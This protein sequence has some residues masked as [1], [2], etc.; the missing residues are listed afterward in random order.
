VYGVAA[1]A[2]GSIPYLLILPSWLAVGPTLG[3]PIYSLVQ[4]SLEKY[5]LF[6]LIQHYG[7]W[8]GLDNYSSVLHDHVFWDT[9]KRT[10]VFTIANVGLTMVSG[11]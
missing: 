10:I 8:I 5:T 1:L 7:K 4:L 3:Y 2:R 11:R 6:E 9:L